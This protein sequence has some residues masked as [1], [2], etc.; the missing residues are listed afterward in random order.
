MTSNDHEISAVIQKN[1][2]NARN[3]AIFVHRLAA[4]FEVCNLKGIKMKTI[5][6]RN[7]FNTQLRRGRG[8]ESI[9]CF[10]N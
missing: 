10:V 4:K 5:L 2:E 6:A 9:F 3:R 1:P 7:N 8:M